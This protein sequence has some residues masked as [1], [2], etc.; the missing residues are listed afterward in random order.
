MNR[1]FVLGVTLA[2]VGLVGYAVGVGMAYPGRAFSVTM[3]MVGVALIAMRRAFE[4][5]PVG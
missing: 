2:A 1:L 4:E 5:G 3:V